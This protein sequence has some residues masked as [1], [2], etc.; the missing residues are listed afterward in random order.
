[1]SQSSDL[2]WCCKKVGVIII[3]C[4]YEMYY[5][6]QIH[7]ASVFLQYKR[8]DVGIL[9]STFVAPKKSSNT[10]SSSCSI[11]F[12]DCIQ[13]VCLI[14]HNAFYIRSSI[15]DIQCTKKPSKSLKMCPRHE[16][17]RPVVSYASHC[18]GV[19]Y[20]PTS[21]S[22]SHKQASSTR[23]SSFQRMTEGKKEDEGERVSITFKYVCV[24]ARKFSGWEGLLTQ[25]WDKRMVSQ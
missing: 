13:K 4:K 11:R 7:L 25:G 2:D 6:V 8:I 1:M 15:F 14:W 17:L 19:E 23:W 10:P 24:R 21:V 5:F 12:I 22:L 16:D 9:H 18:V 3:G 20:F